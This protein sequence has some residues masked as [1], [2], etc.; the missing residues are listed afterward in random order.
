MTEDK[1]LNAAESLVLI[2]RMIENTRNRM[3]GSAGLH[4][5]TWG[6]V[7]VATTLAVWGLASYFDN[8]HWNYLWFML[9]VDRLPHNPPAR[10]RNDRILFPHLRRPGDRHNLEGHRVRRPAGRRPAGGAAH[11]PD[12]GNVHHPAD[13][14]HGNRHHQPDSAVHARHRPEVRRGSYWDRFHSRLPT[15]GT[16]YYSRQD[17]S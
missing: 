1:K 12:S 16:S 13:D 6:Y 11:H 3:A 15:T 4:L 7:T 5:L 9:P 14:R 8:T 2:G 10:I 17:S